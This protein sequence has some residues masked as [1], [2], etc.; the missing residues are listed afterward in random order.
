MITA[1]GSYCYGLIPVTKF[2][3]NQRVRMIA[4]YVVNFI[5]L[6]LA[7]YYIRMCKALGFKLPHTY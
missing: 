1:G 7:S 3:C 6:I 2:S 4:S 5:N